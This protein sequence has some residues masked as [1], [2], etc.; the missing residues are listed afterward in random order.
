LKHKGFA[1]RDREAAVEALAALQTEHDALLE[2]KTHW[3]DLR[4]ATENL[5]LLS[6]LIRRFQANEPELKEL[7]RVRNRSELLEAEHTALQR[8]CKEQE[9]RPAEW[10]QRVDE[11]KATLAE[12][13]AALENAED[14]TAQLEEEHLKARAAEER[15]A[16]VRFFF[17]LSLVV[18]R[19]PKLNGWCYVRTA[20]ASC[21]TR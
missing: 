17:H 9:T 14:R 6:A 11:H 8:R 4:R 3:E 19:W 15:L 10:E 20:R 2:Q 5:D 7:R 12:A 1:S 18:L 16:N 13:Q 21:V